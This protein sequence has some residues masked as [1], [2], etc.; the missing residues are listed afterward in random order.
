M[1]TEK[2]IERWETGAKEAY[3]TAQVLFSLE[4]YNHALFFCHLTV[5]KMLKA[6]VVQKTL[7]HAPYEHNLLKLS[8]LSGLEF[9]KEQLDILD[10]ISAFNISGR[11]DDYKLEFYKKVTKEYAEEY[12]VSTNTLFLWLQKHLTK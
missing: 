4:R 11:Y 2:I 6:L 12:L 1:D 10:E 7:T 9:A 3:K 8:N 5:E